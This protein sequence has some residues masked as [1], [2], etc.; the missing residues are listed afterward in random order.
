MG[1]FIIHNPDGE[2]TVTAY[3]KQELLDE[4]NEG[5]FNEHDWLS[6]I[7]DSSDTNYWG[8]SMLLI[9]GS[10]VTPTPI[11]TITEYKIE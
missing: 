7:P 8:G 9:K 2:T 3:T 6:E 4:L 5:T 10:L 11:E 1:Y